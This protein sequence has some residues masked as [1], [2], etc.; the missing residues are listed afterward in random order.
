M[1][2]F[3]LAGVSRHGTFEWS[4]MPRERSGR[5]DSGV[6]QM[7]KMD[8]EGS[9]QQMTKGITGVPAPSLVSRH[10]NKLYYKGEAGKM[11]CRRTSSQMKMPGRLR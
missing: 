5:L 2:E 1:K 8:E 6:S 11:K 10:S 7:Q 3:K 9:K 4:F